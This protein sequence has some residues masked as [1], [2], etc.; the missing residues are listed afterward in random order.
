[1]KKP[2]S[3]RGGWGRVLRRLLLVVLA[4]AAMLA[5]ALLLVLN[6]IF[7]GPSPTARDLLTMSLIE[8]S[9][10]KWVPGLFLEETLIR[11]IR[12]AEKAEFPD[13]VT[14]TSAL[15]RGPGLG[16]ALRSGGHGGYR[17]G[18]PGGLC[19]QHGSMDKRQETDL[20][21]DLRRTV[22]G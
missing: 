10:T 14:D 2:S 9:A 6:L 12:T 13:E 5:S 22:R 4:A 3:H 15:V 7:N 1:M 21:G 19:G 11:Q 16:E 18:G 17:P 20:H 8:A